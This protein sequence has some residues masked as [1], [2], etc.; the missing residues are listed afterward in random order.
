MSRDSTKRKNTLESQPKAPDSFLLNT[1]T[2]VLEIETYELTFQGS[3]GLLM[4]KQPPL[5]EDVRYSIDGLVDRLTVMSKNT[6]VV[7]IGGAD[8]R[9]V[10]TDNTGGLALD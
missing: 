1:K 6:K 5:N 8:E 2:T 9:I 10:A 3:G 4:H 7:H